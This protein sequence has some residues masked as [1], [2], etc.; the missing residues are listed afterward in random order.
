MPNS[1]IVK[2]VR[3]QFTRLANAGNDRGREHLVAIAPE[4]MARRGG[5]NAALRRKARRLAIANV[6][7]LAAEM[8]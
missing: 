2:E 5:G 6:R 3:E 8:A 1:N 7:R 4:E